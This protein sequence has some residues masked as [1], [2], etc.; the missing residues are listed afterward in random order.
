MTP[1]AMLSKSS[2]LSGRSECLP[3]VRQ[4]LVQ[5]GYGM[6]RDPGKDIAKPGERLDQ[7]MKIRSTAV[8][9]RCRCRRTSGCRGE[10]DVP[11]GP[12][13]RTPFPGGAAVGGRRSSKQSRVLERVEGVGLHLLDI[14]STLERGSR[15]AEDAGVITEL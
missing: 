15:G 4:Q 13:A 14:V 9:P 8:L 2:G 7:A 3:V 5:A 11:V 10:A 12:P 6:R 1:E